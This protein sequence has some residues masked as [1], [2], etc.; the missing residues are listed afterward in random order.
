MLR[1]LGYTES[2]FGASYPYG[3]IGTADALKLTDGIS[4]SMGEPMTRRDI[5][6]LICNALNT[7]S[8]TT[9]QVLFRILPNGTREKC[10]L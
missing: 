3:Q 9:N 6:K 2:D 10:L 8:K 1:V 5:A 4:V 7:K